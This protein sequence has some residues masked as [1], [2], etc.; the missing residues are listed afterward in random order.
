MSQN[1]VVEEWRTF[2][3]V[4]AERIEVDSSTLISWGVK[5]GHYLYFV[6]KGRLRVQ[7]QESQAD[8]Q[9]GGIA[10]LGSGVDRR[11]QSTGPAE[12]IILRIRNR[13]FAPGNG[14]DQI[15]WR[16]LIQAGQ[17]SRLSPR[18]AVSRP[19]R[20]R[21][22]AEAKRLLQTASGEGAVSLPRLKGQVLQLLGLL[23]TDATFRSRARGVPHPN[24]L[25]EQLQRVLLVIEEDVASIGDAC[26]LAERCGLSRSALYRLL[27]EAGMP[28]PGVL[29]E[30]SRL[31]QAIR[32]LRTS[33]RTV[34]S[35][36]IDAGFGSLSA[37]YRAFERSYGKPPGAF[38]SK[39]GSFSS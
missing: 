35:I 12:W 31:E 39:A 21:L 20:D 34:L 7:S 23:E 9:A 24:P 27:A 22:F 14:A 2:N 38:R 30:K 29:L 10:W 11:I 36:A 17:F 32:W 4:E 8:I 6:E 13:L 3:A 25:I 1:V 18:P 26:D 5:S 37:L 15:A 33:D 19:G 16:T 28:S